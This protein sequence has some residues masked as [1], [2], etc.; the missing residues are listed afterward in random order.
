MSV[1]R[2]SGQGRETKSAVPAPVRA[3]SL[4][5]PWIDGTL[6]AEMPE[7]KPPS[8]PSPQRRGKKSPLSLV[9]GITR[10]LLFDAHQRR[11]IMIYVI[12]AALGLTVV[13]GT[14]GFEA[15]R[16]NVWMFMLYW[17]LCA[18]LTLLAVLLAIYDL[19]M[20]RLLARRMQ[21][22]LDARMQEEAERKRESAD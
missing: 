17:L 5:E 18:F 6:T 7:E 4:P 9:V 15:L 8:S 20:L 22:E 21:R 16:A 1:R 12:A 11:Q 13:G 2:G 19:L 14:I 3:L 10:G